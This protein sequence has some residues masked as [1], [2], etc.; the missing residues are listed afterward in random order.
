MKV[1]HY[2]DKYEVGE[3]EVFNLTSNILIF[4]TEKTK[5]EN[6]HRNAVIHKIDTI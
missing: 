6:T 4:I 2:T 1:D 5:Y 3:P